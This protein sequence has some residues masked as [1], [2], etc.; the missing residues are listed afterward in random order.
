MYSLK[1]QWILSLACIV[2]VFLLVSCEEKNEQLSVETQQALNN[3]MQSLAEV[4]GS[5]NRIES[6]YQAVRQ[7]QQTAAKNLDALRIQAE[8][9][10][11]DLAAM[12]SAAGSS[13]LEIEK[14]KQRLATLQN[15]LNLI[16]TGTVTAPP[17]EKRNYTLEVMLSIL[18]VLLLI[19]AIVGALLH[20][21]HSSRRKR[22]SAGASFAPTPEPVADEIPREEK[23]ELGTIRFFGA[24]RTEREKQVGTVIA[25]LEGSV[26]AP[27]EVEEEEPK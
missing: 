12:E 24:A 27:A 20:R 21:R 22:A 11:S 23:S 18:G 16:A 25:P 7:E 5:V 17:P 15:D 8:T 19:G 14:L 13:R 26:P 6:Q 4:Q 10:N 2:G 9:L 1:P 3:V